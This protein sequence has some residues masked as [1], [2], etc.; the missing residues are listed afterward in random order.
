MHT[1]APMLWVCLRGMR[2]YLLHEPIIRE[3]TELPEGVFLKWSFFSPAVG[4][5]DVASSCSRSTP[6]I[7]LQ[8][9]LERLGAVECHLHVLVR[10][11]YLFWMQFM[12]C[13][14][15]RVTSKTLT[16]HII[17][18]WFIAANAQQNIETPAMRSK[19][20]EPFSFFQKLHTSRA[21]PKRLQL[22]TSLIVCSNRLTQATLAL[23]FYDR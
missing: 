22:I 15:W 21:F 13:F 18:A 5:W 10:W 11:L 1:E 8:L 9:N 2:K 16:K 6:Q 17:Y 4:R 7:I 14:E 23:R 12:T 19:D 20:F 3:P